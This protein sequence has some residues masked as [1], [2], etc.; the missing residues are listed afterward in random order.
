MLFQIQK[1]LL[2]LPLI[3]TPLLS[4]AL[5][6]SFFFKLREE[7]NASGQNCLS[8]QIYLRDTEDIHRG[9]LFRNVI[10]FWELYSSLRKYKYLILSNA[11]KSLEVFKSLCLDNLHCR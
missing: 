7:M 5:L 6:S 11:M 2:T 3:N 9:Q 10:I 1:Y 4:V 8:H